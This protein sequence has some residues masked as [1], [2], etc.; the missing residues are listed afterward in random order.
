M[1]E[2]KLVENAHADV[3]KDLFK[4]F[5]DNWTLAKTANDA[6]RVKNAEIVYSNAL[7]LRKDALA[8]ALSL[9]P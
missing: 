6:Q 2:Q 4:T 3:I 7:Q 5:V 8:K 1:N 9:T